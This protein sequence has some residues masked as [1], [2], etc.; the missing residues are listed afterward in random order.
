[1][2]LT[3]QREPWAKVRPVLAPLVALHAEEARG[4]FTGTDFDLD[5]GKFDLLASN[6]TDHWFTARKAG[7]LVGYVAAVID[8]SPFSRRTKCATWVGYFLR[9]DCRKGSTGRIFVK[10]AEKSLWGRGVKMQFTSV[11]VTDDESFARRKGALF[12][13]GGWKLYEHAYVKYRGA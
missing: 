11:P 2:T 9:V 7:D 4:W 13:R 10:A 6:G 3:Y 8:T 1:M 12:K 5:Y